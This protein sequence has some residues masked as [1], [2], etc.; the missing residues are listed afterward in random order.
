MLGGKL[1]STLNENSFKKSVINDHLDASIVIIFIK[2]C[3]CAT[4][5]LLYQ[6]IELQ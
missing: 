4:R 3:E 2:F 1:I 6:E 5:Q